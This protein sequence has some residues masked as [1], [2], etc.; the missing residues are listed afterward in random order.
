E[1]ESG[2]KALGG[3]ADEYVRQVDEHN[4]LAT[5]LAAYEKELPAKQT[6]WERGIHPPHWTILEP[7]SA[8]SAK[9]TV[10]T[11][12]PDGSILASGKNPSPETY[13]ISAE[14]KV[15]GITALRLEVLP[16][17][18]LPAMGPG[19]S[20]TG[21][22]VLN[23][24]QVTAAPPGQTGKAQKVVL[25][26][27]IADFSQEGYGVAG[28]IDDN[29][30]TGWA[31]SPQKG[32]AHEAIF[33]LKDP[34]KLANGATLTFTPL[35]RFRGKDHNIGRLRLSATTAKPPLSI[36]MLPETITRILAVPAEKRTPQQQTELA[37]HYRSTDAEWMRLNQQLA[38]HPLPGDKRLLGAQD[39]AWA[40]INS[41]AFLF[42]H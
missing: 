33:E 26:N 19:R 40:L 38:R 9:G 18:R 2:I 13:T 21:N 24:F 14:T 7:S 32:K 41:P 16:D 20:S 25:Q 39:L 4:R 31:V 22:F 3:E 35:Q 29:P 36:H 37:N 27:A 42:N 8:N 15:S 11:K 28:A 1:I 17:S 6:A 10:L 23:E 34:L 5:A 30:D 12:Q